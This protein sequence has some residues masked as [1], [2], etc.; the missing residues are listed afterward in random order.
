M[1]ANEPENAY[2]HQ[3]R[4]NSISLYVAHMQIKHFLVPFS[5][6]W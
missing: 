2:S 4:K 6:K 3:V 5:Q 1:F